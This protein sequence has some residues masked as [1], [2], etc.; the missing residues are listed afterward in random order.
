MKYGMGSDGRMGEAL[1]VWCSSFL[2]S[3]CV[4]VLSILLL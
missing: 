3:I 4:H 2:P 1:L